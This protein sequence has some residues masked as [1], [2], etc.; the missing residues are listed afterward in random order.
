V[1]SIIAA[2]KFAAYDSGKCLPATI[3]AIAD[4]ARWAEQIMDEIGRRWPGRS[5]VEIRE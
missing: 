4:A 3:S 2:R 1:A 5:E